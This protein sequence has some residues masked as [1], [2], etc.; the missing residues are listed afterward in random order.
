M[1]RLVKFIQQNTLLSILILATALVSSLLWIP[2]KQKPIET[3]QV[4]TETPK[5]PSLAEVLAVTDSNDSISTTEPQQI[6]YSSQKNKKNTTTFTIRWDGTETY[7]NGAL[8]VPDTENIVG[9]MEYSIIPQTTDSEATI[10]LSQS[11]EDNA[12]VNLRALTFSNPEITT[13]I[14]DTKYTVQ[15]I[16]STMEVPDGLIAFNEYNPTQSTPLTSYNKS[17]DS[18]AQYST[19]NIIPRDVWGANTAAWD[20]HSSTDI[21]D[22]ARLSWPPYY[23]GFSRVVIHHTATTNNYTDGAQQMREIYLYHTYSRGWGDVGYNYLIDKYGNIYE[24]KLGGDGVFGYHAYG[25]ANR[26][27]FSV[28]L[29]GNFTNTQPTTAMLNSLKELIAEKAILYG[30]PSLTYSSGALSKWMNPNYTVFGHRDSYFYCYEGHPMYY[31]C[32]GPNQ[33]HIN[34]TACPGNKFWPMLST[35]VSQAENLRKDPTKFTKIRKVSQQVDSSFE[36]TNAEDVYLSVIFDLPE[37]ATEA[38]V[39]DKIPAYSGISDVV[40]NGNEAILTVYDWNNGGFVPEV[41]YTG[42]ALEPNSFFPA[43]KGPTGRVAMLLK[44]FRL[45]DDVISADVRT[46]YE[47]H[48][49]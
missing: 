7:L 19:L 28:S 9:D 24:G 4:H 39:L 3:A 25:P 34:A 14:G 2:P 21:D 17:L 31:L 6:T 36:A 35:V 11:A 46:K 37:T 41:G 33:W 32:D 27:A 20:P 18:G 13:A 29:I 8:L 42:G 49:E 5:Q 44:L 45:R 30:Y 26:M 40:V 12:N 15:Y 10:T 1:K 48:E 38:Q 23:Y 22:P 43:G 16:S 47:L